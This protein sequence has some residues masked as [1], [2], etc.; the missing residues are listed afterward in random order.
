M[1]RLHGTVSFQTNFFFLSSNEDGYTRTSHHQAFHLDGEWRTTTCL[2]KALKA[3][4]RDKRQPCQVASASKDCSGSARAFGLS[5]QDRKKAE[6]GTA[7]VS[8]GQKRGLED[9]FNEA[10]SSATGRVCKELRGFVLVCW[11]EKPGPLLGAGQKDR[12]AFLSHVCRS[13]H[14]LLRKRRRARTRSQAGDCLA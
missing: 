11:Q 5:H 7:A 8:Q 3:L 1:R 2:T 12:S 13:I 4:Q 6:Q 10:S 9:L 14:H